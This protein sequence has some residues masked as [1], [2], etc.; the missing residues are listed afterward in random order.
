MSRSNPRYYVGT[1]PTSHSLDKLLGRW[2]RGFEKRVQDRPEKIFIAWDLVVGSRIAA[3][4]RPISFERGVLRVYVQNATL[5][6]LLA[7]AERAHIVRQLKTQHHL[8]IQN[9]H[10]IR[11]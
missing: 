7:G 5:L 2:L 6:S 1:G 8:P 3:L 4:T 9:I 11:G 10:F